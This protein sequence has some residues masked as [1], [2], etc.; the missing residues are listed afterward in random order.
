MIRRLAL[1]FALPFFTLH[2][3]TSPSSAEQARPNVILVMTDDQG[4]GD[5]SCH[6]NP[7]LKTPH[8]D[9]LAAESLRLTSFHVTPMCTPT[10]GQLLTGL[11]AL[12][13]GAMNVSSGRTLLRRGIPTMADLFAAAGYQCGQ[14]GKWHLGDNYPYRPQDRGFHE[15]LWYASSHIGSAADAWNN[16]YFDDIYWHNGRREQFEGYTTDVFFREAL[17]W[18]GE[19]A[20]ANE[21]FFCYI[22]TAAAHGPLFVPDRYRQPYKDQPRNVASFFGML[23]NIDENMGRLESFLKDRKL[24]DNTIVVFLTD[25][26]GTAG[27]PVFNAGMRG[28]KIEL[29]EGG[30][31]AACFIRWPAG[32]L[33][34][35]GEIAELTQVQDL[36]PTLLDLCGIPK[37]DDA[38]FDGISLAGLLRG[39]TDKLPDRKLVIQF[40]RMNAP[41]PRRGD[42]CVLW[43]RWRLV[44]GDEL[45]DV[46]ADPAQRQNVAE[47]HP[48]IVAELRQ[49]YDRWW[50]AVSPEINHFSRVIIGADAESPT[51]LSPCEWADVFL[52]QMAQVRRGERK[53]GVWHLEVEM[54][55]KYEFTLRRWPAE[56]D[57]P[58]VAASPE[59]RGTDG[60]YPPGVALP[61]AKARI[62]I[63]E[64]DQSAPIGADD[65]A[66][67]FQTALEKGPVELQTWFYDADGGAICGAYLVEIRRL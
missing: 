15:S 55:G 13:N 62:K 48:D 3:L 42:A 34:P 8:L 26:G 67:T 57:L 56:A 21:P 43:N 9:Q 19:K 47:K 12:R 6:G 52:D 22:P 32:K 29:Y 25:N 35:P 11:D 17:R 2:L 39:E 37:R 58:I 66:V 10:R 51:R 7:V 54:G 20:D 23:A 64:L 60:S 44:N 18:M 1:I 5:F 28:R 27:V 38:H 50:Q 63:G 33:Q 65:K 36:L 46:A 4:Y 41:V 45:Y 59:H 53:N 30:H 49:H 31:R 40:S 14:F 61:I 16:D 24:R